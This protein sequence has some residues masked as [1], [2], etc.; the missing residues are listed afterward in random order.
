MN[1][2]TEEE[3]IFDWIVPYLISFIQHLLNFSVLYKFLYN[4]FFKC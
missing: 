2:A 4:L 3:P 1:Q